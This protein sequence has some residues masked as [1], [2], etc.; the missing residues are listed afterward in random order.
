MLQLWYKIAH[1]SG[2]KVYSLVIGI[3]SLSI[4]ARWLGPEGRGMLAAVTTWVGLFSTVGYLS[5]GQA[6]IYRATEKRNENWL[7]PTLGSLLLLTAIISCVGWGVA[8]SLYAVTEGEIFEHLSPAVLFAGFLA[9]PFSV[10]EQYG[11]SLLMAIDRLTVYNNAQIVARTISVL[12]VVWA[13]LINAPLVSALVIALVSQALVALAGLDILFAQAAPRVRPDWGTMKALLSGGIKLHLNAIGMVLIASTDVLL[14]THYHGTTETGHYQLAMQ[15]VNVLLILPHST[16]QVLYGKIT[17]MGPDSAWFYQRKMLLWVTLGMIVIAGAAAVLSPWVI[18]LI[19]GPGFAASIT[20]FRLL[21]VALVGMTFSVVV[22]PQWIG[23]G[24]FWQ[25]AAITF[26]LG[27]LNL[28]VG[29]L[30]IP[31]YGMYGAV[32]G[33]I[34]TYTISVL[35]NGGMAVWC[36]MRYGRQTAC[37][38][39]IAGGAE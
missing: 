35:T 37:A 27:V 23:R 1:T 38:A 30:L 28:V 2:A 22:A 13:M 31:T 36:E 8:L 7:A 32:I 4:T 12:L 14:I 11:S 21:L 6:A 25:A 39:G 24:M 26:I 9:L 19:A 10:W 34:V 33:T 20:P 3:V 16:S 15:L 18:P 29:L 17:Q 5:L